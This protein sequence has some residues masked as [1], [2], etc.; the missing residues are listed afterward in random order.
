[1]LD[2]LDED[3]LRFCLSEI[4][5]IVKESEERLAAVSEL[6]ELHGAAEGPA[7]L[8]VLLHVHVASSRA[9]RPS[10]GWRRRPRRWARAPAT[11]GATRPAG[12]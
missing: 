8:L 10:R 7:G 11:A 5:R 6:A 2:P 3:A 4:R 12:G 1:M 9:V